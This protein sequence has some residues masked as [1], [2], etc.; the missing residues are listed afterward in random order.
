V[1]EDPQRLTAVLELLRES[2]AVSTADLSWVIAGLLLL[3]ALATMRLRGLPL[4]RDFGERPP[5]P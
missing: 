2:L 4:R 5:E 3:A 1:A